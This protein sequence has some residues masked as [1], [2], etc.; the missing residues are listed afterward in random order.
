[1]VEVVFSNLIF[2]LLAACIT[3]L[4]FFARDAH[5]S[6]IVNREKQKEDRR[7]FQRLTILFDRLLCS[8]NDQDS[9]FNSRSVQSEL[10]EEFPYL[11]DAR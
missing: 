10:R 1:M 9:T 7:K 6:T 3:G 5:R 8:L 11:N 2:P 4:F